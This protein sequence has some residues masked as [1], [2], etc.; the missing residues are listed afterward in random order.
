MIGGHAF[1]LLA[2]FMTSQKL[3]EVEYVDIHKVLQ[4][5]LKPKP[6]KIAE[7]FYKQNQQLAKTS[8]ISSTQEQL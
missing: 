5:H 8:D 6:I 3:D 1:K 2:N 7:R 4:A